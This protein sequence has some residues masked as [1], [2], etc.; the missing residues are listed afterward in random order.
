MSFFGDLSKREILVRVLF[1]FSLF[2]L[3]GIYVYYGKIN[4]TDLA[5]SNYNTEAG[6][7]P[8]FYAT[9]GSVEAFD[10]EMLNV[11]IS[12]DISIN[13]SDYTGRA[14]IMNIKNEN[15]IIKVDIN[16][17]ST[18]EL[19]Y[20]SGYINSE[21][22]IEYIELNTPLEVGV[23]PATASFRAYDK[24]SKEYV[25]IVVIDV[26]VTIVKSL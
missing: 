19:I 22:M 21:E 3:I 1:C 11:S 5:S 23:Y 16:L 14:N 7:N 15:Q 4:S 17:E 20:Q 9:L 18:G 24:D 12:S 8:T 25:N 10:P 26:N 6:P 2:V 13:N